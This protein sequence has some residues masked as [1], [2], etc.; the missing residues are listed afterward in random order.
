MNRDER[1]ARQQILARQLR[2]ARQLL[3][4]GRPADK[5]YPYYAGE[6]ETMLQLLIDAAG[7]AAPRAARYTAR[8]GAA[9]FTPDPSRPPRGQ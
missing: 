6:L 4:R 1:A 7:P 5:G 3:A 8:A 9:R 2:Q